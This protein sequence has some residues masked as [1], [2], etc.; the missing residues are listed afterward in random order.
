MDD[1]AKKN[2]CR[3]TI[4]HLRQLNMYKLNIYQ[5][6]ILFDLILALND[7]IVGSLLP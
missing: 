5:K 3:K 6:I 7:E 2:H 4:K 1:H